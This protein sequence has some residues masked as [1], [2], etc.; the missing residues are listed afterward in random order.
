MSDNF[1]WYELMTTD[2]EAA[3]AFYGA[4]VGWNLSEGGKPGMPYTVVSAGTRGVGGIMA[5]S[6]AALE[7]GARPAWMGYIGVD[8]T[9]ARTRRVAAAGGRIL[10]EPADIP[11]V[12]RFAVVADP[13]GAAFM[14][15]TPFPRA[16]M[17]PPAE[18]GTPGTFGW[19]ELY[20]GNG[21]EAAFAFYSQQFGWAS[22]ELMDMGPMGKY[23]IFSVDGVQCGGMMDKPADMPA[24]AWAF[25]INVDGI[26]A[27]VANV[28]ANGGK[29]LMGPHQVPGGRWIIQGADP[30]GAHFAAV[31]PNR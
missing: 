22:D 4:V 19:N 15:L 28:H 17:P 7:T 3:R 6:T 12:G 8:D 21:E 24:A 29:V 16:D 2:V 23:R 20:A 5:L 1:I 9:D 31:S 10:R 13:G 11:D 14:L 30:Q 26:D 27:V 25:Y 18:P